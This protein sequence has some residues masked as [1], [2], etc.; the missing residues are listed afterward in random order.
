M[1][2]FVI[3]NFSHMS[4]MNFIKSYYLTKRIRAKNIIRIDKYYL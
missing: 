4:R 3:N 2:G 1:Y